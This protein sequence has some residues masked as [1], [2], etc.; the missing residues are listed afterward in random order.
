MRSQIWTPTAD[1]CADFTMNL[2]QAANTYD[3]C[4]ASGDVAIWGMGVLCTVAGKA[5]P[6]NPSTRQ[7]V[8]YSTLTN[9]G[10]YVPTISEC[11]DDNTWPAV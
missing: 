5:R 4:T 1:L 10:P 8:P 6:F 2:A 11:D 9:L 3:L 7:W